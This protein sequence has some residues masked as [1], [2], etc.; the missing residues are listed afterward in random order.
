M[1]TTKYN[2]RT[3]TCDIRAAQCKDE[4]I[5]YEKKKKKEPPNVTNI[6]SNMMLKLYNV[7]MESS[8]MRKKIREPPNVTKE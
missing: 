8:N 5:K 3:V 6:L 7:R 1:K 2:K 4:T